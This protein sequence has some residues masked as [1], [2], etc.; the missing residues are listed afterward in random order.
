MNNEYTDTKT[1]E[2][3]YDVIN[4]MSYK[5]VSIIKRDKNTY[6]SKV[7]DPA[8]F[9]YILIEGVVISSLVGTSGNNITLYYTN[10]SGI[11]ILPKEDEENI[12]GYLYDVKVDSDTATFYKID[13]NKFW[14]MVNQDKIL[15]KY[16]N[17]YYYRDI[18]KGIMLLGQNLTNSRHGQVC[19]FLYRCADR[20]GKKCDLNSIITIDCKI[21]NE[22][23]SEFYRINNRSS[24]TK[25]VGN[26]IKEHVIEQNSRVI[27]IIDIDY[28]RK[29]SN[30]FLVRYRCVVV[31][32]L[33]LKESSTLERGP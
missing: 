28:L 9:E 8:L 27:K 11:I 1:L 22:T 4:S 18:E 32:Y 17:G 31:K 25:I 5:D 3:F 23:I 6:T 16:M 15:N 14:N 33:Y 30:D 19:T 24:V 20:F 29:C 13:R 21:T 12:D 7:N 2:H 10:K 26:L